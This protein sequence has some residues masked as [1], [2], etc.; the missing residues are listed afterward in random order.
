MNV[1]RRVGSWPYPKIQLWW[2]VNGTWIDRKLEAKCKLGQS[3]I[4]K[5]KPMKS[6]SHAV[7][8]NIAEK[9]LMEDLL[10]SMKIK[11]RQIPRAILKGA[12]KP[13]AIL[14]TQSIKRF[15][16]I[17]RLTQRKPISI[18]RGELRR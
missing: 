15:V 7:P 6:I 11:Q 13:V 9:R 16:I 1:T 4:A 5:G 3:C 18:E 14:W 12:E 10:R 17:F 2:C 8:V